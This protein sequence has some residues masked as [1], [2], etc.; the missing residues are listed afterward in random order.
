MGTGEAVTL[1]NFA[2]AE[3]AHYF[4]EQLA[5]AP[6]NEYFH[7][8]VPVDV[9]NQVIIR[10]NVDLIYSYAVVDVTERATVSLAPSEEYAVDQ[11]IDENHYVV[12]VVYPGET[13]TLTDD[14][15]SGGTHVYILGRTATT[16]G[17][18]RA[19][20][21]QD[22]RRIDA[23]TA[24]PYTPPVYDHDSLVAMRRQ[25]EARAAEADFSLGFGTPES[26]TPLQHALAA[27][28]GWGGL[29]P[30]HAQYFQGRAV[31]T[32]C[33]S[34]TFDVPPLDYEHNGYFSVIKYDDAGWLDVDR[35][36]FSDTELER[37]PDGTITIW[38]GDERCAGKPNVIETREGQEFFHGIR[39]YRPRDVDETR[40]FIERLRSTPLVPGDAV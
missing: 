40:A 21:L 28:L 4:T 39:L 1:D 11:I 36:G 10:S 37:N 9:E 2:H 26:T 23:A 17:V 32:G 13:L 38:F 31:S 24:H 29:P 5:K 3:T 12:G 33:D 16:S 6:V 8:R 19:H 14:D 35:P 25:I 27:E 18:E 22:R 7:N 30:Q 20:E 34:W 15:L